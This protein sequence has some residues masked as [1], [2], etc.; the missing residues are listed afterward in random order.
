MKKYLFGAIGTVMIAA[1]T[2]CTVHAQ[3][4]DSLCIKDGALCIAGS[5]APNAVVSVMITESNYVSVE[6]PEGVYDF[7]DKYGE[8][9]V[10]MQNADSNGE[11]EFVVP[12]P[13][14]KGSYQVVITTGIEKETIEY[15]HLSTKEERDEFVK[16]LADFSGSSTELLE[17][18]LQYSATLGLEFDTFSNTQKIAFV[19]TIRANSNELK[20]NGYDGLKKL[21]DTSLRQ[22]VFLDKLSN[23]SLWSQVSALVQEYND[24]LNLDLSD[25]NKLKNPDLV[26]KDFVGKT[27]NTIYDFVEKYKAKIKER[28]YAENK[29]NTSGNGGGGGGGGAG[30]IGY[31]PPADNNKNEQPSVNPPDENNVEFSD[32]DSVPWAAEA[33][34]ELKKRGAVSGVTDT[35]FEPNRQITREEFVKIVSVAFEY[36]KSEKQSRFEDVVAGSW[37]EPYIS[38]MENSGII[39]GISET[40]F[41]VGTYISRA[42]AAVILVRLAEKN[43]IEFSKTDAKFADEALIKDYAKE[44]VHKLNGSGIVSG[45]GDNRFDPLGNLTRAEAAK[46][47]YA[48]LYYQEV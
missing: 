5:S 20:E 44:A 16:E 3:T 38:A 2:F 34:D 6:D 17:K 40:C 22:N 45:K 8:G 42:D 43:G 15:H 48:L 32:L 10:N 7:K 31:Y 23:T 25:Y 39:S 46:M 1:A 29:S 18:L 4:I 27:Y 41:G 36:P 21:Y 9:Y 26:D 47:I 30:I 13:Y 14:A 28:S 19:E 37:Y 11:Y 33:I 12:F 35:C 24:I